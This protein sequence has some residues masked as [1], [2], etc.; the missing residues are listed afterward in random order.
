[1]RSKYLYYGIYI[2]ILLLIGFMV[3]MFFSTRHTQ[4][5]TD[6]TT[7]LTIIK[8]SQKETTLFEEKVTTT[9]E[10]NTTIPTTSLK[11]PNKTNSSKTVSSKSS[12]PTSTTL[13]TITTEK[14]MAA[15]NLELINKIRNNY[16]YEVSYNSESFWYNGKSS[17]YLTDEKIANKALNGLISASSFFP[18]GFFSKLKKA[19]GFRVLLFNDISGAAGVTSY[20]FGDDY[21]V[22][23]DVNEGFL[24]RN[25]YHEIWHVLEQYIIYYGG[26]FDDWNT[27]NPT[28]FS[29]GNDNSSTY[30]ILNY[31]GVNGKI[32]YNDGPEKTCFVSKYGKSSN[33][34][35]KA[36]I[37]ADLM[38]RSYQKD[39]MKSGYCIN[40]KAKKLALILRNYFYSSAPSWER[41][42]S[43]N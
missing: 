30:T 13:T 27:L 15:T 18:S 37:F 33:K 4:K 42:I 17:E 11:E 24:N 39:Y 38:F 43:W 32:I 34:E 5:A 25:Y 35:D 2:V 40:E 23:L 14:N 1:M 20:E 41:W 22:A 21:I 28:G 29:Y 36:E 31:T 10:S 12:S 19:H 8:D 26:S 3:N 16:G 9:S 7:N 6:L